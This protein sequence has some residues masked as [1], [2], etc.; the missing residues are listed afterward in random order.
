MNATPNPSATITAATLTELLE[1]NRGA[2][3]SITYLEGERDT[4]SVTY[5]ELYQRALA[6]LHWVRGLA[7]T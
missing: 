2:A 7:T 5:G 4:R 6:I 3:R 1:T